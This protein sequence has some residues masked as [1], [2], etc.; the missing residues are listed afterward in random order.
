VATVSKISDL[1]IKESFV[2]VFE[3][4]APDV[5]TNLGRKA[6]ERRL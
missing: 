4:T 5:K 6:K 2:M 1:W 3:D